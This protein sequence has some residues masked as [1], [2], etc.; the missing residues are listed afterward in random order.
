MKKK[1]K[2][3][4]P[5]MSRALFAFF[6]YFSLLVNPMLAEATPPTRRIM[7]ITIDLY[8]AGVW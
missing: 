5:V 8:S 7:P 6:F 2:G 1:L 3:L 4:W